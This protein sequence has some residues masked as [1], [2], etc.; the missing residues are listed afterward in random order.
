MALI[1]VPRRCKRCESPVGMLESSHPPARQWWMCSLC[2][3]LADRR[4]AFFPPYPI[5]GFLFARGA[6]EVFVAATLLQHHGVEPAVACIDREMAELDAI[7]LTF[8]D[9]GGVFHRFYIKGA[10]HSD[11]VSSSC[12][13]RPGAPG[14]LPR[15]KQKSQSPSLHAQGSQNDSDAQGESS[16]A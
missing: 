14:F 12:K 6:G 2:G 13:R 4:G 7:A 5:A 1:A 3:L 9:E 11:A 15:L 8:E 10:P 16:S